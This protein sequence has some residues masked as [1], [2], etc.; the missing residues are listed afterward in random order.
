MGRHIRALYTV[1]EVNRGLYMSMYQL[2]HF[3]AHF[4]IILACGGHLWCCIKGY[5]PEVLF[6]RVPCSTI[7]MLFLSNFSIHHVHT[8]HFN[9]ACS[10][11]VK[12]DYENG[13]DPPLCVAVT[14]R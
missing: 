5:S 13:D 1:P 10:A 9:S 11:M 2:Y 6:L 12:G 4:D 14:Q 3:G 7:C 8:V